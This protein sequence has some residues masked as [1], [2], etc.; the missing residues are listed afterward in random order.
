MSNFINQNF[1]EIIAGLFVFD[2]I[3]FFVYLK[4][5]RLSYFLTFIELLLSGVLLGVRFFGSPSEDLIAF[6][7]IGL[8]FLAAWAIYAVFVPAP[9]KKRRSRPLL[10][11]I[12]DSGGKKS[13]EPYHTL[14]RQ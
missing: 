12:L 14:C 2:T 10:E 5:D 7:D 9:K 6:I 8:F 4:K 11:R 1:L 3:M 13:K